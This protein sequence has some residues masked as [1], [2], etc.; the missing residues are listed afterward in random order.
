MRCECCGQLIQA[1]YGVDL[2]PLELEIYRFVVR[3]GPEGINCITLM[4]NLFAHRA[5]GGPEYASQTVW[6]TKHS[7]NKKL[8]SKLVAVQATSR[9]RHA[10]YKL[11]QL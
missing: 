8:K 5:D 3:A 10:R 6:V 11:V 7:L 1:P 4:N 2:S 9:G